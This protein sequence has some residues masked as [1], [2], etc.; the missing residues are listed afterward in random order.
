MTHPPLPE[1]KQ[2][3]EREKKMD[4]WMDKDVNG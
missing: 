2:K 1:E 3:K 4:G